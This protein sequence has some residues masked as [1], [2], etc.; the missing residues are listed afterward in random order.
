[1][2]VFSMTSSDSQ[3]MGRIGE[4]ALRTWQTADKMKKQRGTMEGDDK[5][6]DNNRVKRY[7][8]KYTINPAIAHGI[9]DYIGSVEVGKMDDLVIWDP[10]FF[11]VKP[12]MILKNGM[13]VKSLM[14][15]P[16]ATIPTPQPMLYRSMFG[17]YGKGLSHSSITFVSQ[18][19][20]NNNIKENLVLEKMELPVHG[21]RQRTEKE[22]KVNSARQKMNEGDKTKHVR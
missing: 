22:P 18:V 17:A 1:M 21:I 7:I 13:A 12:E 4:V 14:G 20:Y 9:S 3:A 16:N 11:G 15:D 5:L 6:S 10:Q 19:A 8:A 2:G